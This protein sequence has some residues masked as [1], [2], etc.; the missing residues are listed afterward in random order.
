MEIINSIIY[1]LNGSFIFMIPLLIVAL[2]AMFSEKSGV[3]NISM[4][5]TM[6]FGAF[7]GAIL[8]RG[9]QEAGSTINPHLLYLI[10]G[11][12]AA[13]AGALFSLLLA[14]SAINMKS[15][16]TIAG[17]ALNMLAPA[18]T[19]YI[20]MSTRQVKNVQFNPEPF[21]IKD[22]VDGVTYNQIPYLG[23]IPYIG[24]LLFQNITIMTIIGFIIW[25]IV[26]FV[27]YKTRFG[28]RLSACGE[29]PQAVDSVGVNVYKYRY[30]GVILSGALAGLGGLI[31]VFESTGVSWQGDVHGY[32]FL[33]IAVLIFGQWK[34]NKILWAAVFFGVTRSIGNRYTVFPIF[35]GVTIKWFFDML[36]YIATMVVLVFTSKKSRAPKAVGI[37]YDKGLR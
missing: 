20:A 33:A 24:P 23:R 22:V 11:V 37:P 34:P 7:V 30:L 31:Y 5:G 13:A 1:V 35:E 36:P 18:L 21:F 32:G 8:L 16:Q 9:V 17:T 27:I 4:E 2:G 10:C 19:V 29:H 3:V 26:Y 15:D 12:I 28:L 14:F 6:V 25:A